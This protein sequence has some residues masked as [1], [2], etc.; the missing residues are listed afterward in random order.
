MAIASGSAAEMQSR[1]RIQTCG[2][3]KPKTERL[4]SL[5]VFRGAT[6]AAILLVNDAFFYSA[7]PHS[8]RN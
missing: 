8:E 1:N 6:V 5:D 4:L 3:A 2:D 7:K